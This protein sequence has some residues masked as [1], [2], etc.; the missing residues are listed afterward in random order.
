MEASPTK[1]L[2][3]SKITVALAALLIVLAKICSAN[4]CAHSI[5]HTLQAQA[6]AALLIVLAIALRAIAHHFVGF[7]IASK[8]ALSQPPHGAPG[9]T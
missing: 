3:R 1:N 6:L 7:A 2:G 4:L 5:A 9:R 8:L